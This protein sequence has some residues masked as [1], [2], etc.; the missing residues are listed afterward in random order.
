[1]RYNLPVGSFSTPS[2]V[3]FCPR[4]PGRISMPPGA[5]VARLGRFSLQDGLPTARMEKTASALE[6]SNHAEEAWPPAWG[7]TGNPS[8]RKDVRL[9]GLYAKR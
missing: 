8:S 6:A 9:S 5:P 3:C 2:W 4:V 7:E 1:M